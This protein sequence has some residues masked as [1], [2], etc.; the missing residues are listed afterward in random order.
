MAAA[1][2]TESFDY[3]IV[4]AGSAGCVLANRLSADPN[5]RVLLLEAGG[6]DLYHWIHIPVGYLYTIGNP[7]TD[8]MFQTE[9]EKGLGDR[10]IGY[11]RGK[12]LGG[13]SSINGMIY[14][15]GQAEDYDGWAQAGNTGWSWADVLPVFKK[16]ERFYDGAS[17][18]HG[19]EGELRVDKQRLKWAVL[20][21]VRDAAQ[22]I[23][24]PHS[25]D[26]NT[27][28]NEGVGYF[29]VTQKG[30]LR[31]SAVRA[32]LNPAR[33]RPNLKITTKAT[34]EKVT[35]K[36]GRATGI[37]YRVNGKEMQA[38]AARE[39]ILSAGAIGSPHLLQLSG[40]GDGETLGEHGI[41]VVHHLPGVGRNLQDHLQIRA[42]YGVTGIPTLNQFANSL[43]GRMRMGLEFALRR[44]GPLT[45]APSQLGIFAKSNER[46][47]TPNIEFHVQPLST[48][49]LGERLHD[50]PGVTASV[51]NLRPTSRGSVTLRSKDPAQ[52]PKIAPN[53]LATPEDE[54]VAV[55]SL[56]YA[57]R[58][59]ETQAMAPYTPKE[60]KPGPE[61][62]SDDDLLKAAQRLGTTIFHPVGTAKMGSDSMAV[63]DRDLR[64]HG[65]QGL[66]VVD[67]SVMP[68]IT[69]G[70]TNAPTMMIAE[71]AS[72]AILKAARA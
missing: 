8:W 52:T 24:L 38:L 53:Y 58:L 39:V 32:F 19:A 11:A 10:A 13:S 46:Y 22:E 2:E 15:R 7:R 49:K 5:T 37:A 36:D 25:H 44:T 23:G 33:K 40:I 21:A 61:A 47:A 48:E 62:V 43:F 70:N 26:F 56:R 20:D 54:M 18:F 29:H 31:W 68:T 3:I 60:L 50:F 9:V 34:V 30:G 6:R 12:V 69:S 27:G 55:E 45:M 17:E 1:R 14:M 28:D 4:G 35:V 65:L 67:A 41:D 71:K 72:E 66:R 63:V 42:V 16:F 64:V 59:F 51:C 57:R